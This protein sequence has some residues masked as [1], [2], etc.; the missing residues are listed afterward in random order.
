MTETLTTPSE[1]VL[2]V[3]PDRVTISSDQVVIEAK[4]EMPDWNVRELNHVPLYFG[5]N[6]YYL[7]EKSKAR[8]P[9]ATRY[10]L[11]PWPEGQSTSAK[12]L[13]TYDLDAVKEREQ[14]NR[15][16][17][18]DDVGRAFLMPLYPFLGLLWSDNQKR[19]IRFGFV[20]H[21]ISGISIFICFGFLLGQGIF[22][23]ILLNA[24]ARAGHFMIGGFVR[25]MVSADYVHIGSLSI[26]V[27][28]FDS[29]LVIALLLDVPIRFARYF[30][31]DQWCGGFLEWIVRSEPRED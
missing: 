27:A 8:P 13:Y 31:E 2:K 19:L 16:G 4:H 7:V 11:V 26:P 15:S 18:F 14:S 1:R 21:S 22:A 9:Y 28:L 24:G 3:G 29:L 23:A 5:E 12:G 30:H 6:K 20:P 10:V 25:A 17:N